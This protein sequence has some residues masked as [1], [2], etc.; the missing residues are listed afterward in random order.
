MPDRNQD[1]IPVRVDQDPAL[2][3]QETLRLAQA[4]RDACENVQRSWVAFLRAPGASTSVFE[5]TN[6]ALALEI[7]TILWCGHRDAQNRAAERH[8][9]LIAHVSGGLLEV[10][11]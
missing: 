4:Y 8:R 5:V 6:T 7:R 9:A 2:W 10:G 3:A 1:E 11:Q